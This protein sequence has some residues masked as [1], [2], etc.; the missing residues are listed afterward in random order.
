MLASLV[1][2]TNDGTTWI[3]GDAILGEDWLRAWRYYWPN[4]YGPD[5]IVETW[6]SVARIL[7]MADV[8]IPGHGPP[9]RVD[10]SLMSDSI[11]IYLQLMNYKNILMQT[12]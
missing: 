2:A 11:L 7:S 3:V 1:V 4:G 10:I 12:I 6:R 9:F 8:V 5:E